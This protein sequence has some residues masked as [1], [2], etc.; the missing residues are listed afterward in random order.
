MLWVLR[1]QHTVVEIYSANRFGILALGCGFSTVDETSY[2]KE[3]GDC[4]LSLSLALLL[5]CWL[6][7]YE[8]SR[9]L[10]VGALSLWA[11]QLW[12]HLTVLYQ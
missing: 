7:W 4:S 3:G 9:Q 1:K 8:Q 6:E 11:E 10:A 12:W 5:S 2:K